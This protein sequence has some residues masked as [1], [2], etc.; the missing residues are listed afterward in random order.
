MNARHSVL[1]AMGMLA[2][3]GCDEV[4]QTSHNSVRLGMSR[5]DLRARFGEPLRIEKAAAGGEDWYYRF[6]SWTTNPAGGPGTTEAGYE[7]LS[8]FSV[9]WE[10]SRNS[11]VRPVH[12][13]AEGV[14][15]E[16]VP[17]GKVKGK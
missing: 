13:S 15:I 14:V 6:I 8:Y 11:E 5:E 2:L 4:P 1:L 7:K 16:P 9:G 17:D 3:L 12:L 10:A